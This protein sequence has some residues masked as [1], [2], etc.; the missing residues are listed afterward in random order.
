VLIQFRV[1]N[2]R[3]L[4]DEQTLSLV[5]ASKDSDSYLLQL[6][7][8]EE[9]LLPAI[10]I[11]GANASG[12][13]NVL[14]ALAFMRNAVAHS[15]RLWEPE[16]GVPQEPFALSV[17]KN[18]NSSYEVD[19]YISGTRYRYGFAISSERVEKEWLHAW[20]NG[21]KQM[22]FEREGTTFDFGRM[23]QGE[24]ET[25]RGL[26]RENSLFLSAG[27]QNNHPSLLPIF[28]W[29]RELTFEVRRA[30]P[31]GTRPYGMGSMVQGRVFEE[32]FS[33]QTS[34]FPD[35]DPLF[36]DREA[37]VR[38]LQAA[39]TGIVDVRVDR[40]PDESRGRGGRV[41]L[42]FQHKTSEPESAWLPL[43]VESAGTV[44]LLDLAI[45][46]VPTLRTGGILCVDEIESSLHP[47]LAGALLRLFCSK[48]TNA[49][50]AQLIFTTHDTNLLG[51][52]LGSEA[53]RRDQIWF[54]EKDKSGASHLYPLTDFHPRREENLERGYLQGRY[55]AVPF[56]GD[57]VCSGSDE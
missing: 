3:S 52:V 16:A 49:N 23:F 32:L 29:F 46:L 53:L 35:D 24:N 10:A 34:L 44:A 50:G 37:I 21:R 15:H 36:N 12:K 26:T 6:P 31:F 42:F 57:L 2:H 33:R 8:V 14:L 25:I 40:A 1:Q 19:A 51:S 18:E 39:D 55:G 45:R 56:L 7:G 5:A 43:D 27:A 48:E 22:W 30:R 38:L 17:S 41:T 4:R 47:M 54:T 28:R 13:T 20:P 9:D 11:Y